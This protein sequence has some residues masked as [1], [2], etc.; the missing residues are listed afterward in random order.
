MQYLTVKDLAK[1][2]DCSKTTIYNLLRYSNI[3]RV[4]IGRRYYIPE[5]AFDSWME[6]N[7][8]VTVQVIYTGN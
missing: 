4:R 6:K 3:P 5:K 1:K 8:G 7:T 2:L